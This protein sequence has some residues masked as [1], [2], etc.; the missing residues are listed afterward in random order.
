MATEPYEV[1]IEPEDPSRGMSARLGVWLGIVAVLG[2]GALAVALSNTNDDGEGDGSP[3][4]DDQEAVAV[5]ASGPYD[6]LESVGLPVV[7]NP[8]TGLTDG[9]LVEITAS[10]F[11]SNLQVAIVQCWVGTGATTGVGDCDA[12]NYQLDSS[13][14]QGNVVSTFPVRRFISTGL[15]ERDC[16]TVSDGECILAVANITNY[17]ESGGTATYFDPTAAGE[18]AA[19]LNVRPAAGL[20]DGDT[21]TVTGSNFTPND[22]VRITQC[23]MNTSG[24]P[25][26]FSSNDTGEIE[27]DSNGGFVVTIEADRVVG[28]IYG[29]VDCGLSPYGCSVLVAG[30]K[31]PSPI[32]L[33]YET[34]DRPS[35]GPSY[36]V[37]PSDNLVDSDLVTVRLT[38]LRAGGGFVIEQCVDVAQAAACTQ[39]A[40]GVGSDGVID[41]SVVVR[42]VLDVDD[43]TTRDCAEQGRTCYLR[44]ETEYQEVERLPIHFEAV[45]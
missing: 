31:I 35:N 21:I 28:G 44:V 8:S 10:G 23:E 25:G 19:T 5:D 15:G 27:V 6:G 42:R 18:S 14:D 33:Q 4:R 22:L 1:P 32:K 16:A 7:V 34:S 38:D 29:D 45:A 12:G 3:S 13:D 20:V 39:V 41:E 30:Q 37:T 11:T 17:D 24:I 2:A 36:S 9:Q 26:C 40:S 43:G